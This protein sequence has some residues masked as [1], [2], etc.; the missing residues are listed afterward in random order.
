MIYTPYFL[1]L[2]FITWE[3]WSHILGALCT[4]ELCG[5]KEFA[6]WG[7]RIREEPQDRVRAEL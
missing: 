2:D 3:C 4:L 5:R 6:D 1:A 7:G